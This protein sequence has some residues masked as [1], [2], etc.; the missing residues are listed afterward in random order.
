MRILSINTYSQ[1]NPPTSP[2]ED[3]ATVLNP[4]TNYGRDNE[5]NNGDSIS[6]GPASST[7]PAYHNRQ[8]MVLAIQWIYLIVG[9]LTFMGV[10]AVLRG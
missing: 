8:W 1:N 10:W 4:T 5:Y 7:P 2:F 3:M 9:S 6:P